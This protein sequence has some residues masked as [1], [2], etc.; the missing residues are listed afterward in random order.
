M[1]QFAAFPFCTLWIYVQIPKLFLGGFP[2]S[3]ISGSMAMCA[4]PKL[5]AAYHV[6][7]RLPVPRHST[8]CSFLL[9]LHVVALLLL[10]L[11]LLVSS[12]SIFD[13]YFF[14]YSVFKVHH[15]RFCSDAMEIAR[16]ELA[17][18]CLQGRCSPN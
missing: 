16:F 9:D 2:H 3:D 4:S 11:F 1:F 15:H 18:P 5:F 13:S 7:L 8:L 10:S 14:L 6:L 12:F 17:T